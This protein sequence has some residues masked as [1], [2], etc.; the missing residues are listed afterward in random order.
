METIKTDPKTIIPEYDF[1]LFDADGTLLDTIELIYKSFF[2]TITVLKNEL[3][4]K[5]EYT[6]EEITAN[7]GIPLRNQMEL[8]FGSLS[9]DKYQEIR[10][11]YKTYQQNIYKDYLKLFPNIKS[12]LKKLKDKGKIM[13]KVTSRSMTSAKPYLETTGIYN[14]FDV[15]ITPEATEKHKPNPEPVLEAM[16]RLGSN[17]KNTV[18]I[19]DAIADIKAGNTAGI[20]TVFVNWSHNP[21]SQLREDPNYAIDSLSELVAF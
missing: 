17:K 14:F 6:R 9:E 21:L 8:Y 16:R 3:Y 18:F 4:D 10:S 15:I 7:I 2:H 19:G 12:G 20:D 11:V 5:K 1:Y 13:G